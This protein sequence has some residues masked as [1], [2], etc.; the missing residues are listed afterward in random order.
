MES[1][2]QDLIDAIL[3]VDYAME[4]EMIILSIYRHIKKMKNNKKLGNS[5]VRK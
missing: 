5:P 4:R 3:N 1:G 2:G